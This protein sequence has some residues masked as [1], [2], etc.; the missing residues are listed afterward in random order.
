[1]TDLDIIK[2]I[3]NELSIELEQSRKIEWSSKGYTLNQ[4]GQ[5]TGLAQLRQLKFFSFNFAA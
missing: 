3:E 5:V 4:N 1:M 2:K